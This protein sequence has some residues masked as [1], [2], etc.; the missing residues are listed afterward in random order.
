MD[1][2]YIEGPIARSRRERKARAIARFKVI[3]IAAFLLAAFVAAGISD[4]AALM[5]GTIS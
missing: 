3:M 5:A 4:H 1:H 2:T